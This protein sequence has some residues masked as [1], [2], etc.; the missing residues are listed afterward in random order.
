MESPPDSL[1]HAAEMAGQAHVFEDWHKL[2]LNQQ[3]QLLHQLQ[4]GKHHSTPHNDAPS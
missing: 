4:V 3:I 1:L 2:T